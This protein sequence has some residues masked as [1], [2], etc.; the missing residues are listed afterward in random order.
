MQVMF[1]T[2]LANVSSVYLTLLMMHNIIT[3]AWIPTTKG[4]GIGLTKINNLILSLENKYS[5][6]FYSIYI[7]LYQDPLERNIPHLDLIINMHIIDKR[8]FLIL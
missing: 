1:I 2:P 5:I 3:C 8:K 7:L 4:S 6:L